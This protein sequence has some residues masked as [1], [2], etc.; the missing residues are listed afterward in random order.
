[1]V[2]E[3]KRKPVGSER[4]RGMK[5]QANKRGKDIGEDFLHP[6]G[7]DQRAIDKNKLIIS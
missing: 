1:V 2:A 3:L 6:D 5:V 4:L 7:F